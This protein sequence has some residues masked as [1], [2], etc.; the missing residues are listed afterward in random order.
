MASWSDN[1]FQDAAWTLFTELAG[2]GTV[3]AVR[4]A[5]GGNPG[6]CRKVTN[7]LPGANGVA[8]GFHFLNTATYTPSSDGA[9]A[10]VAFSIDAQL[11]SSTHGSPTHDGIAFGVSLRQNSKNYYRWSSNTNNTPGVWH[12]YSSG[13][14]TANQ[15]RTVED[16]N[17]HPDFTSSGTVILFGIYS[18][19]TSVG[20]GYDTVARFDNWGVTT[21]P[22]GGGGGGDPSGV[23]SL[24]RVRSHISVDAGS[25]LKATTLLAVEAD[26]REDFLEGAELNQGALHAFIEAL[27]PSETSLQYYP[28]GTQ[29]NERLSTY[30]GETVLGRMARTYPRRIMGKVEDLL[31]GSPVTA[32]AQEAIDYIFQTWADD[33]EWFRYATV[34]DLRVA[35][36]AGD[37]SSNQGRL[38]TATVRIPQTRRGR[39]SMREVVDQ[40]LS[41]FP[42]SMLT[43]D[44]LGRVRIAVRDGPDADATPFK[45]LSDDD[46]YSVSTGFPDQ[47][48]SV[49]AATANNTGDTLEEGVSVMQAAWFQVGPDGLS[50]LDSHW[51]TA[52]ADHLD[53]STQGPR[54]R[55]PAIW[56]LVDADETILDGVLSWVDESSN[57]LLAGEINY[58]TAGNIVNETNSTPHSD[59]EFEDVTSLPLDGSWYHVWTLRRSFAGGL[60]YYIA[61]RAR[62]R[63]ELGGVEFDVYDRQLTGALWHSLNWYASGF[64]VMGVN[65]DALGNKYGN[66]VT[67]SASFSLTNGDVLVGE[68]GSNA[69][70]DSVDLYGEREDI[71]N[72]TVFDLSVEQLQQVAQAHV[73]RNINPTTVRTVDQ[74]V[75]DAFP[76]KFTDAGRLIQLP[77]GEEGIALSRSYDDDFGSNYGPGSMSSFVDVEVIQAD[78][79]VTDPDSASTF[80]HLNSG[81]LWIMDD[82]SPSEVN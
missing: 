12:E 66:S 34:P 62:Y 8:L 37:Y 65:L 48:T 29:N 32:T 6:A 73:L 60:S 67:K 13:A 20:A 78:D 35:N 82:G 23:T 1:D 77:S 30:A 50:S 41:A 10:S 74:S 58:W 71:I 11:V 64:A 57:M 69:L 18:G 39:L 3:A 9:I 31:S 54:S 70:Q 44:N 24:D 14:L 81:E 33:H 40:W 25:V 53:L 47:R 26:I 75:W 16:P 21:T 7:L 46:A 61:V 4:E 55:W 38:T 27:T 63:L 45:T 2:G 52:P 56:P 19:N 51:F 79:Y 28:A 42:G 22:T 49:N 36:P 17:D 68:G 76:I 5:S 72:I 15:F 43:L 59:F 80:L